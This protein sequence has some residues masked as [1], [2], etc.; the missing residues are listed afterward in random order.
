MGSGLSIF[1]ES[2]QKTLTKLLPG[3]QE[4][5]ALQFDKGMVKARI[6]REID[7]H[8]TAGSRSG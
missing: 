8:K 6:E 1:F 5:A 4:E 3:M 7:S 2:R